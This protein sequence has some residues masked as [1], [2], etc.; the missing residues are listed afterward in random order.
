MVDN[1]RFVIAEVAVRQA[2]HETVTE[3]VQLLCGASLWDTRTAR[4]VAR[5][6]ERG[7]RERG[8]SGQGGV[9]RSNPVNMELPEG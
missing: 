1:Q 4:V 7:S 6:G 3:R 8:R 5:Q 2:E 9:R